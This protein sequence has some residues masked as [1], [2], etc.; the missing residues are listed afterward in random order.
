MTM[1][2]H[3]FLTPA[4]PAE[5]EIVIKKSRFIGQLRPVRW[6]DEAEAAL[7]AIRT[8]HKTAT[9]NC[10]AYTVGLGV[11]I[12]RF[13]DDGEPSGTAGRPI[14]EVLRRRQ[15]MNALIVV[16]RYFGGT[17]LG[18]NGLVRAYTEG[19]ASVIDSGQLLTCK[20]MQPVHITLDYSRFGKLEHELTNAGWVIRDKQFTEQVHLSLWV[21]YA[22]AAALTQQIADWTDG[23]A[24]VEMG[25]AQYVGEDQAGNLVFDVWPDAGATDDPAGE[26]R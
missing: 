4:G 3:E 16:T 5:T 26:S 7:E 6:V 21:P 24:V 11:P 10:Y 13:S 22:D 8:E 14:L 23:Q 1:K 25:P 9:H 12:E 2:Q 15:V 17:L 19:A 20:V 18:A